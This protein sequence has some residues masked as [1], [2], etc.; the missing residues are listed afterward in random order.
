MEAGVTLGWHRWVGDR[1]L[2]LGIDRFGASAPGNTLMEKLG[3]T[4]KHFVEAARSLG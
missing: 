3:I 2:A 1:G 4:A